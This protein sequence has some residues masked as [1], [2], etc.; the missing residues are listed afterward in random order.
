MDSLPTLM[1][2]RLTL[3]SFFD[4]DVEQVT[5][6]ASDK[7]IADVTANIPHPYPD[8]LAAQWI[9]THKDKWQ[10]KHFAT[11]AVTLTDTQQLIGCISLGERE[12]EK[13]EISY[14]LGVDFWG[15][16]YASEACKR[17]VEFGFDE[18]QLNCIYGRV[19]TRNSASGK[20]LLKVGFSHSGKSESEC[21]YRQLV[22]PIEYYE[23]TR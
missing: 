23:I 1:T 22:E 14:W 4:S 2:E 10:Q 18:M 3:R 19:L 9:S 5:V 7:R 20:V 11:Y 13:G 16:G 8:D 15:K 17:I 21:G 6:L 12:E